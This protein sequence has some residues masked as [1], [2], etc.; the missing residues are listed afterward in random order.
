MHWFAC[1]LITTA[2]VNKVAAA[3][4]VPVFGKGMFLAMALVGVYKYGI[5]ALKSTYTC[6]IKKEF[7][8]SY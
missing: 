1:A 8:I 5:A 7:H 6:T 3:G 2:L 4:R